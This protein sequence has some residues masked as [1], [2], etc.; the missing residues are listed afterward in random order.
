MK[1]RFTILT[2]AL[3][4]LVSLAIPMGVWGQTREEVSLV[5]L[6]FPDDNSENNGLT[7]NQ[8]Q[9]TWT[10]IIG[11]FSWDISNFNNNNWANN[12]AYIK[13]GRKNNASVGTIMTHDAY[14]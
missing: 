6:T 11:D 7:S 2:A 9:S 10:A 3:A 4:L 12:W 8:Y 1:R 13:C 5:A 14:E